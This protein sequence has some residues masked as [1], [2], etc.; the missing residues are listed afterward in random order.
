[1]TADEHSDRAFWLLIIGL[2]VGLVLIAYRFPR[3][4]LVIA[5]ALVGAVALVRL[6]V[7]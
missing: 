6:G 7:V 5:A 3:T 2:G 4:S 1:M